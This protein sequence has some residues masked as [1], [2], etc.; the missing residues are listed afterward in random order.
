[1]FRIWHAVPRLAVLL[2][3]FRFRVRRCEFLASDGDSV[4]RPVA[5]CQAHHYQTDEGLRSWVE[6]DRETVER[7]SNGLQSAVLPEAVEAAYAEPV[8]RLD[9]VYRHGIESLS[10]DCET[11]NERKQ[12]DDDL[13]FGK[14][15]L[16]LEI[17]INELSYM[18]LYSN[19]F[20]LVL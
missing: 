19:G 3:R 4:E 8:R 18:D 12:S 6:R 2:S 7:H 17:L 5:G 15:I 11:E 1:M 16:S 20:L 10:S 14:A 9:V 13:W